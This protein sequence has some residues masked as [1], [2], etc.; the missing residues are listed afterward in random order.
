MD[1]EEKNQMQPELFNIGEQITTKKDKAHHG[2]GLQNM[3][4]TILKYEGIEKVEIED[5]V[6]ILSIM[7]PRTN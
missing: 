3:R 4:E 2:F 1:M 5:G 6:F 7:I